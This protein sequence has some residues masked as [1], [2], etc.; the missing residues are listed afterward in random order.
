MASAK[1]KDKAQRRSRV[2]REIKNKAKL[3]LQ[4]MG[5]RNAV[6]SGLI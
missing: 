1:G 6:G 5:E 2:S 4:N 3:E